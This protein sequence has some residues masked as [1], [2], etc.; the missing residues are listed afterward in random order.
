MEG[1]DPR[2]RGNNQEARECWKGWIPASARNNQE[3][4]ECWKGWVPASARN[5]QEARGML[6]GMD[7]RLRGN[8]EG[9]RERWGCEGDGRGR[10]PTRDAPTGK[11]RGPA[12]R[13]LGWL[14]CAR[15][16]GWGRAVPVPL[17][18]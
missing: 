9:V 10:T 5:N 16:Y 7:S 14:R 8:K 17:R 3:A 12:T 18:G 15:N 2:L 13:F 4:R 1:M 6:E 11:C